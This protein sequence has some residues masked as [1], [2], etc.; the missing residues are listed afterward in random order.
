MTSLLVTVLSG[1]EDLPAVV[2]SGVKDF[3]P[4]I[5]LSGAED[6]LLGTILSGVTDFLLVIVLSGVTDFLLVIILSG[7]TD[8]LLPTLLSGVTDFLGRWEGTAKGD[9]GLAEHFL[10]WLREAKDSWVLLRNLL[11]KG[12]WSGDC[13]SS[14]GDDDDDD[15]EDGDDDNDSD[16]LPLS[17]FEYFVA[18]KLIL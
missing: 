9:D 3:L 1:V 5:L 18:V 12:T 2:L 4:I 10:G 7:V 11:G 17:A 16:V 15:D 13:V 6:V 8:F 14:G